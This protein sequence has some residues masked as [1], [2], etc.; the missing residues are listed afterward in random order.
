MSIRKPNMTPCKTPVSVQPLPE[1]LQNFEEVSQGYTLEEAQAEA[2]RCMNCPDRYC[3][4]HCPAHSYIPEFIACVR[5]GNLLEAWNLLAR[6]NPMMEIAGRVCPYEN[7]CESHCTRG[8]RSEPVAIGR[9]ERFV[10]DWYRRNVSH[11]EHPPEP[12]GHSV[13]IVGAGPAG[14]TCAISLAISGFRVVVYEKEEVTGGVA[15]WGIP[16]F[17][18]PPFCLERQMETLRQLQVEFRMNT[19]V[20]VDVTLEE[21]KA[22]YDAVFLSTG[23]QEPV[24]LSVEGCQ[25]EGVVQAK[26]YLSAPADF[27]GQRV[28]ILGG[29]NT[30]ID[31]ARTALRRNAQTVQLVYRRTQ[32]DMPATREE[33]DIA[34]EEGVQ[35]VPLTSPVRFVTRDGKLTGVECDRMELTAPDYPG[36]RNNVAPSGQRIVLEADLAVLALGFK[37]IPVD[38]FPVD[39]SGRIPV[40]RSY[41]T[42][43]EG[44]Y[45]GGDAVTGPATLMKAVAAGKNAAAVIFTRLCD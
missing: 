13:A 24:E 23:A 27:T 17:V 39:G 22:E 19:E 9:L 3:A 31:A 43:M 2:S 32:A 30:A 18:L 41:E 16:T 6:T 45:A 10:A 8:I 29:G 4:A 36:G 28:V 25:A 7:Q 21:L 34:L 5:E 12:N 37:P 14:L 40:D 44:V 15:S 33:L 35:L 20:G 11:E 42:S 1:R 26:N 38:G